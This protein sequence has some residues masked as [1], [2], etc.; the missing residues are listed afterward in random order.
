MGSRSLMSLVV[1]AGMY[2]VPQTAGMISISAITN[3][4]DPMARE[5]WHIAHGDK[6]AQCEYDDGAPNQLFGHNGT[7]A[8]SMFACSSAARPGGSCPRRNLRT[9]PWP[10]WRISAMAL[11]PAITV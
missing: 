7:P 5:V 2:I 6:T 10:T 11:C 1:M 4:E 9:S 3:D 8:L